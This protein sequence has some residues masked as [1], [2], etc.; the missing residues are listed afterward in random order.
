MRRFTTYHQIYCSLKEA[1]G[2]AQSYK[3]RHHRD[4]CSGGAPA[5]PLAE[6]SSGSEFGIQKVRTVDAATNMTRRGAHFKHAA[7]PIWLFQHAIWWI[8]PQEECKLYSKMRTLAFCTRF[9]N[10]TMINERD[11]HYN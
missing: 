4:T 10:C 1:R 6:A 3:W 7:T 8:K 9:A 11:I 2:R 5:S